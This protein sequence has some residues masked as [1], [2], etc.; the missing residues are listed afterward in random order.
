M[1]EKV[2]FSS[3]RD[4]TCKRAARGCLFLPQAT[5]PQ[6]SIRSIIDPATLPPSP[7]PSYLSPSNG[8]LAEL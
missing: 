6:T 8:L 1:R 5:V 3:G 4:Y 7:L 2:V